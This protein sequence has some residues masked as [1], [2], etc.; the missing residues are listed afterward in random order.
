MSE[1]LV[2]LVARRKVWLL[3]GVFGALIAHTLEI[4]L[5]GLAFYW[6]GLQG[7]LGSLSG[8][9]SETLMENVYFSISNYT[10]LGI[11]DIYSTGPLRFVAGFE[12]LTGLVLITWTASF[13]FLGM[14]KAWGRPNR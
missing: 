5:Y 14:Q 2:G 13:L 11:G 6:I 3:I 10:S 1:R 9:A 12:A 4:W 7:D 8:N